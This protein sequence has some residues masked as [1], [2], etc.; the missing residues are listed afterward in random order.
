MGDCTS[1]T[2]SIVLHRNKTY[3]RE[4]SFQSTQLIKP[5]PPQTSSNVMVTVSVVPEQEEPI[6]ESEDEDDKFSLPSIVHRES[7]EIDK[8][9]EESKKAIKTSSKGSVRKVRSVQSR[10][11]IV[12]TSSSSHARYD[13]S[14][15][16]DS[17]TEVI[18]RD[19]AGVSPS[20]PYLPYDDEND[21]DG[22]AVEVKRDILDY[23]TESEIITFRPSKKSLIADDEFEDD[24][25]LKEFKDIIDKGYYAITKNGLLAYVSK[26]LGVIA[27]KP[28]KFKPFSTSD[29]PEE[30]LKK[31]F[32]CQSL[33]DS[34]LYTV[35][36]YGNLDEEYSDVEEISLAEYTTPVIKKLGMKSSVRPPLPFVEDED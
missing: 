8:I 3:G 14:D 11:D 16:Y 31:E 35:C 5:R 17:R 30:W 24:A 4:R 9:L 27:P 12:V 22:D 1:D 29:K 15:Y 34:E 10:K 25:A 26:T 23:D 21:D 33:Y 18:R 6:K 20:K 13:V 7:K 32:A 2:K 36:D 28:S 19:E